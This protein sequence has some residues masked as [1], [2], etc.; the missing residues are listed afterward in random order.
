MLD[1]FSGRTQ[2]EPCLLFVPTVKGSRVCAVCRF[3]LN[4]H[5]PTPFF[6]INGTT[7]TD[8]S[9]NFTAIKKP[10]PFL[11]PPPSSIDTNTNHYSPNNLQ[12]TEKPVLSRSETSAFS[13]YKKKRSSDDWTLNPESFENDSENGRKSY[14]LQK[15]STFST[16]GIACKLKPELHLMYSDFQFDELPSIQNDNTKKNGL[17]NDFSTANVSQTQLQPKPQQQQQQQSAGDVSKVSPNNSGLSSAER[18]TSPVSEKVIPRST[19]F[20]QILDRFQRASEQHIKQQTYSGVRIRYPAFYSDNNIIDEA[21][22]C[23]MRRSLIESTPSALSNDVRYSKYQVLD[24]NNCKDSDVNISN[25]ILLELKKKLDPL[26]SSP[27]TISIPSLKSNHHRYTLPKCWTE[28][29]ETNIDDIP[30]TPTL[31]DSST[32]S[33]SSVHKLSSQPF[34]IISKKQSQ[35]PKLNRGCYRALS[36]STIEENRSKRSNASVQDSSEKS[37]MRNTTTAYKGS[38]S[39]RSPVSSNDGT[40]NNSPE[41]PCPQAPSRSSKGFSPCSIPPPTPTSIDRTALLEEAHNQITLKHAE[42][43]SFVSEKISEYIR[44]RDDILTRQELNR[45]FIFAKRHFDLELVSDLQLMVV[46]A[47]SSLFFDAFVVGKNGSVD[48]TVVVC[49]E[50]YLLTNSIAPTSQYLPL[51]LSTR[52]SNSNLWCPPI[53]AV[54]DENS[55]EIRQFLQDSNLANRMVKSFIMPRLNL[56]SF[57]TLAAHNLDKKMKTEEYER[58]VCFIMMQL[59]CTLKSLQSDGVEVLSNNFREF[60]LAYRYTYLNSAG[61]TKEYP[62]ILL[63]YETISETIEESCKDSVG[64]CKYALRALCTLLH[65]KMDNNVP[66]IP[67]VSILLQAFNDIIPPLFQKCAELLHQERSSSLTEVK[68]ILEYSFWIGGDIYF[69]TEFEA[70]LWLDK[71]RVEQIS[72]I[73]QLLID[74][75]DEIEETYERLHLQFL[76][77]VT[78]RTLFQSSETLRNSLC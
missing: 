72:H 39:I 9:S 49:F 52:T 7:S 69:D 27:L 25:D 44:R 14:N 55:K 34:N 10:C 6:C 16:S 20:K 59:V 22:R 76:L 24:G 33:S 67:H 37:F 68:N 26:Y 70:K 43:L 30:S 71:R 47:G 53:L 74:N 77:S 51:S 61:Q 63:L 40:L 5:P 64:V 15:S 8:S 3:P 75:P 17:L 57:H 35:N 19:N 29:K 1:P 21:E 4:D 36:A 18:Y 38:N 65:H 42:I 62:R 28:V 78:P 54:I 66:C 73:L 50:D 45:Y 11:A 58:H 23:K 56:L 60:L 48:V 31:S 41:P 2:T 12:E 32:I 46:F 13:Q